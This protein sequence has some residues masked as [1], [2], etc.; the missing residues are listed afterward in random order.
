MLSLIILF[1]ALINCISSEYF[2]RNG[3]IVDSSGRA[4]IFHGTNFV[5]KAY[6]WYPSTLLSVENVKQM[7][8]WGFNTVR[9]GVMWTGV[10]PEI[11]VFNETYIGIIN[12]ILH[13][14][15]EHGIH[16]LIDVHQ[17]VLS[18]HFCLYDGAPTWVVDLSNSTAHAFPWPLA[19]DGSE[20]CPSSRPWGQNY[21]AEATGA[22]FQDLYDNVNGMRDYFEAFWTKVA[23]SFKHN[24][25]L[26]YEIINEPWAGNIYAQPSLL[27][28]GVAGRNNLQPF[29]DHVAG[30]IRAEDGTHLVFYE[31][32]TWGMIFNG[33]LTGSG[34]SHV[35][36]GAS[37]AEK[38]VFSFHYYCWWYGDGKDF[39]RQTCDRMFGPKVFDQ[40][41]Q[42][43]QVGYCSFH[44]QL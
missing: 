17:D 32:V 23:A 34:F 29:Y 40:V 4:R 36:G 25:I 27:L 38:S 12:Q 37:F 9:L 15:E 42:D 35:P 26:G 22:A 16:A 39:N 18:S 3:L 19:W 13:N 44:Y 2:S 31:P 8:D 30:A 20:P 6:P 43:V 10:N 33:S 14:L 11:G 7:A 1:L 5:Q 28:P 24:N 21:L 41:A